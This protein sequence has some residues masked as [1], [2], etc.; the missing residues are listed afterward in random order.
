MT[1]QVQEEVNEKGKCESK[2]LV[3]PRNAKRIPSLC[4]DIHHS[5]SLGFPVTQGLADAG[6]DR[7][8]I[9][10]EIFRQMKAVLT[11]NGEEWRERE[12]AVPQWVSEGYPIKGFSDLFKSRSDMV[13][14]CLQWRALRKVRL[15]RYPVLV[16]A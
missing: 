12:G 3:P 4:Q 9:R 10:G 16:W 13:R 15:L 2:G 5:S 14:P 6:H 11:G 1:K 7:D 8:F